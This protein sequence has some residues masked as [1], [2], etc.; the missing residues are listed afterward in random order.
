MKMRIYTLDNI[1]HFPDNDGGWF[2]GL[3]RNENGHIGIYEI[4][5]G[6]GY[7]KIFLS[8]NPKIYYQMV[9]DI[10]IQLFTK[11]ELPRLSD[12]EFDAR[13]ILRDEERKNAKRWDRDTEI[14]E[15]FLDS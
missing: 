7:G 5:P 3:V 9:V 2:Y 12:E 14:F 13:N 15:E 6:I 10:F 11:K 8:W 1:E 4:F